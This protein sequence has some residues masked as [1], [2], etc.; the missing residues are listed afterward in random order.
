MMIDTPGYYKL[1]MALFLEG[2]AILSSDA[3]FGVRS[4]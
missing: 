3:I 2:D 4:L 1:T